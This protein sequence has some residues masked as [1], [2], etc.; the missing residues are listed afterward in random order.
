M[1]FNWLARQVGD[2]AAHIVHKARPRVPLMH[3][4]IVTTTSESKSTIAVLTT[5]EEKM[6]LQIE[7]L[8]VASLS[9]SPPGS[10]RS[11]CI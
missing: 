11:S 1:K 2:L 8:A 6:M 3:E 5:A 9:R 7:T 4:N 10:P